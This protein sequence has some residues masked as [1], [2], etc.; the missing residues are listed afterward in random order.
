MTEE[1]LEGILAWLS[2]NS[3]TLWFLAYWGV[4][5]LL[6]GLEFALP[7]F[8]QPPE[9]EKRWSTN[10]GLGIV[11]MM[12]APLAPVSAVWGAQW[13]QD[14]GFGLL[15]WISGLFWVAVLATF[16]IR[17]LAGYLFHVS[18]HKVPLF[19]RMHRV[20]HLDTH[21]D[22]S[23]SLRSH[24]LEFAAMFLTMVPIAIAFGLDPWALAAFEI[25]ESLISLLCHA[26]LR[27]RER[28]D[29]PL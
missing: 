12:L 20:H 22:V 23:T 28:R 25:V 3:A 10:L 9:R 15:N 13:A 7:A 6:A 11:N 2:S 19:W 5:A 14:H 1:M 18:M 21:L 8:Q 16:A 17:S 29:R 27:L 26:N 4:L 24:P